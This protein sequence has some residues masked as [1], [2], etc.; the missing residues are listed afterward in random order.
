MVNAG[1]EPKPHAG[2]Q[3]CNAIP[4]DAYAQ[5]NRK[6]PCPNCPDESNE[7]SVEEEIKKIQYLLAEAHIKAKEL[8]PK[9]RC[10][11][12]LLRINLLIEGLEIFSKMN[13]FADAYRMTTD[14]WRNWVTRLFEN[15]IGPTSLAV[16]ENKGQ[17]QEEKPAQ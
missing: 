5:R 10:G 9:I 12:C 17:K 13:I 4:K 2:I 15:E 16:P 1:A 14:K 6:M 7:S 8:I 11:R 3:L